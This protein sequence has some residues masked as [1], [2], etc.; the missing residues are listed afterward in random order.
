MLSLLIV[1]GTMFG[2]GWAP[3]LYCS[4]YTGI[5]YSAETGEI[6]HSERWAYQYATFR[7]LYP[8]ENP[9]LGLCSSTPKTT[10]GA[11]GPMLKPSNSRSR[12]PLSQTKISNQ[13]PKLV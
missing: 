4:C 7:A 3:E 6:L 2:P 13:K 9:P 5:Q 1:L 11:A 8:T 12:N 10:P